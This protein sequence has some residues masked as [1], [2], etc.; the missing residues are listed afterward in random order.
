[1]T[2][3]I[4]WLF[5]NNKDSQKIALSEK[6]SAITYNKLYKRILS[7][8]KTLSE[9]IGS[10]KNILL[11][12]ENSIFFV[13]AYLSII[14]SGNVCIPLKY[15]RN[16]DLKKLKDLTNS[17][18]IFIPEKYS[19]LVN[20]LDFENILNE[21]FMKKEN[22]LENYKLG[23]FH[24]DK[25]AVIMFTSGSTNEPKGVM[26]SHKNIIHNT[27]SIISGLD[28]SERDKILVVLPFYY[29]FGASLLHTHLRAGAEIIINN[30]FMFPQNILDNLIKKQCTGIAGV[31]TIFQILLRKTKIK[32]MNFPYM[33][34]VQQAGGKL[35]DSYLKELI[36][37]FGQD[38]I[39]IMYGQT[40]ATARLSILN[41][42]YLGG[43]LGSIG[44][45]VEGTELFILDSDGNPIKDGEIG[46]ICA[47]G[48]NVMLGYYNDKEETK[49]KIVN[50]ILRTGD[51]GK[52]DKDGFIFIT[53]RKS[54]FIKTRGHRVSIKKIEEIISEIPGIVEVAIIGVEDN[55]FGEKIIAYISA[56]KVTPK[57][58]S[59]YCSKKLQ[60]HEI[61]S[62]F[63]FLKELPKTQSLKVDYIRL[64]EE[65]SPKNV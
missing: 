2:N 52:I 58:I 39:F 40:E 55:P 64:Q 60:S 5:E 21:N 43:K 38:K 17:K 59:S 63:I 23:D 53:G 11:I 36:E 15:D 20:N 61:P 12:S 27:K 19:N 54:D 16:L 56:D 8:S 29:C 41:P 4:E 49:K 42:K 62:E 37:I 13:I 6:E 3:L 47:K 18:T 33:R 10:D 45:G 57:E 14:A 28:I 26:I 24:P 32:E 50:E 30:D 31:P 9:L 44:K 65:H 48:D 22:L 25:I 34:C 35:A 51:L 46:E 7:N 1:M